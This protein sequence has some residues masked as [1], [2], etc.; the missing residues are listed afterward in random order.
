[1]LALTPMVIYN[2]K[3]PQI[4]I[5]DFNLAD[6]NIAKYNIFERTYTKL[7]GQTKKTKNIIEIKF[8][9]Y[10]LYNVN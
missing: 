7:F 1:M 6:G 4:Q 5:R 3:A 10:P 9:A 2:I 8:Y